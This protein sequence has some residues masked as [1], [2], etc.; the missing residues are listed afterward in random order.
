MVVVK[1]E[2]EHILRRYV[3]HNGVLCLCVARK[4]EI[5]NVHVEIA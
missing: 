3:V 1:H 2:Q 5:H 4:A